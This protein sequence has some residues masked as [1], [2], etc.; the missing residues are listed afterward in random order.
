M[1]A[2][3]VGV[4]MFFPHLLSTAWKHMSL[5]LA[6]YNVHWRSLE[7]SASRSSFNGADGIWKRG[8][9]VHGVWF[10]IITL[11]SLLLGFSTP[12]LN[13]V[14]FAEEYSR[15]HT[16]TYIHKDKITRDGLSRR[17]KII[18]LDKFKQTIWLISRGWKCLSISRSVEVNQIL[19]A[20]IKI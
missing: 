6:P 20:V 16:Y 17:A 4:L 8:A 9:P 3:Q 13:I 10:G 19:I 14:T 1:N 2:I 7:A 11:I 12:G 15:K 5:C 18:S